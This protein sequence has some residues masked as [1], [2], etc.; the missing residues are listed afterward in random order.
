MLK[1]YIQ[2]EQTIFDKQV[3]TFNEDGRTPIEELYKSYYKL[4]ESGNW[5]VEKITDSKMIWNGKAVSFPILAFKTKIKGPSI[6]LFSGI[7]GEEPTGPNALAQSIDTLNELAQKTPVV[8]VPLCNPLGYFR[9]WR[10][11]NK[12]K[13]TDNPEVEGMSVG[14]SEHFLL[15]LKENDK[16]RKTNPANNTC[17]AL[18][19]FIL[20]KIKDY[21]ATISVDFHGDVLLPRGYVYSHGRHGANDKLAVKCVEILKNNGIPI[22]EEGETRFGEKINKGI[23]EAQDGSIDELLSAKEIIKDG[24][25]QPGPNVETVL[26]LETP[27][28]TIPIEKRIK[29]Y[30]AVINYLKGL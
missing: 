10:Y 20:D 5:E 22:Q 13:F 19:Q 9:N 18:T 16:L 17:L 23:I 3:D 6:Y 21:P 24:K 8:I 26:V 29:A 27:D 30:M 14:D 12:E 11:L 7:H 2:K 15:D 4:L 28:A 1:K 25:K